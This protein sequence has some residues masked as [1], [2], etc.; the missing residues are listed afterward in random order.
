LI[1]VLPETH[2][3]HKR[4]LNFYG[5]P[6]ISIGIPESRVPIPS[7]RHRSLLKARLKLARAPHPFCGSCGKSRG[8]PSRRL[9]ELGEEATKW[10]EEVG[11]LTWLLNLSSRLKAATGILQEMMA[12]MT[13]RINDEIAQMQKS[14]D[15]KPTKQSPATP[16]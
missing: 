9:V 6:S 3:D 8:R 11:V 16:N 7:A 15:P 10:P 2:K 1:K 14:D 12:K 13:Q 5:R 4:L